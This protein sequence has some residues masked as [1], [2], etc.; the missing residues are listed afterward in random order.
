MNKKIVVVEK[1]NLE[2]SRPKPRIIHGVVVSEEEWRDHC[3][4]RDPRSVR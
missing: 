3:S 1:K 4:R 2:I